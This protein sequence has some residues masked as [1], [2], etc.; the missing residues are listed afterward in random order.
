MGDVHFNSDLNICITT[1]A[2]ACQHCTFLL[3]F[4]LANAKAIY[5]CYVKYCLKRFLTNTSATNKAPSAYL[6]K[7]YIH[8]P[9]PT[10][11]SAVR[12]N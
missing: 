8:H 2:T 1:W 5:S 9:E 12:G 10:A 11:Q 7:R 4:N 6:S 3:C